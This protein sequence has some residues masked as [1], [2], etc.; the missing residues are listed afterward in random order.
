MSRWA[1]ENFDQKK[2]SAEIRAFVKKNNISTR[3][4]TKIMHTPYTSFC[5]IERKE[6]GL[7]IKTAQS[8]LK[9]MSDYNAKKPIAALPPARSP[10]SRPSR[11]GSR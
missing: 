5:R 9:A 4:F 3:Q 7:T 11:R 1:L 2:F 6:H 10:V 8:L